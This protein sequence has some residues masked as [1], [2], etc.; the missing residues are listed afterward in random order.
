MPVLN[1]NSAMLEVQ[2]AMV[3]CLLADST[4]TGLVTGVFDGNLINQ[5]FPYIS[6]GSVTEVDYRPA[7]QNIGKEVTLFFDVW[8][9]EV[10]KELGEQIIREMNRTLGVGSASSVLQSNLPM[11]HYQMDDL[12]CEVVTIMEER[13]TGT[14]TLYHAPVRYR[15][16]NRSV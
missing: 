11:T 8:W 3:T 2:Q 16:R 7:F 15:S 9:T 10:G 14:F 13:P 12:A 6:V 4:I 1:Q 5:V